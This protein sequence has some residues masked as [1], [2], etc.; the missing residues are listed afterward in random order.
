MPPPK[1]FIELT[2]LLQHFY[3]DFI[4]ALGDLFVNT[5][6]LL[7]VGWEYVYKH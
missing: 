5:D 7:D 2:L 1:Y 6:T 3:D 4:R